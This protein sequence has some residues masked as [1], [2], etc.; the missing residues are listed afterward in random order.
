MT[1]M[2]WKLFERRDNVLIYIFKIF[3]LDQ[4]SAHNMLLI[5]IFNIQN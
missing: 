4:C 2:E 1:G 3:K 5:N